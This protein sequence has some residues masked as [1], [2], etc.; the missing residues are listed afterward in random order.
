[1][2]PKTLVIC[3]LTI[4]ATAG[5]SLV[6]SGPRLPMPERFLSAPVSVS[7][8]FALVARSSSSVPAVLVASPAS[9]KTDQGPWCSIWLAGDPATCSVTATS[10]AQCSTLTGC[11]EWPFLKP[12]HRWIAAA[13]PERRRSKTL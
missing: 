13:L 6:D 3:C 9:V 2:D 10:G 8:S 5:W 7:T 4:S 1:M 12:R 11:P